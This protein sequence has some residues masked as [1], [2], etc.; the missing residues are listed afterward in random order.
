MNRLL[1]GLRWWSVIQ[2]DGT[3][4]WMFE[5]RNTENKANKVDYYFFWGSLVINFIFWTVFA[6]LN[7]IGFSFM[8]VKSFSMV[9]F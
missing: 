8:W 5:S 6:I 7:T 2:S 3:E 1:V 4:K 9:S